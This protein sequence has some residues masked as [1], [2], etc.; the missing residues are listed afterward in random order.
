[1]ATEHEVKVS[2][3]LALESVYGEEM[4]YAVDAGH[5]RVVG[6]VDERYELLRSE[7]AEYLPPDDQALLKRSFEFAQAAHDGQCRKSGE[8]FIAHPVEVALILASLR[9]DAETLAAALLHDVVEDTA[10]TYDQML[11]EFGESIAQLVDG[12]T[13]I[14]RVEVES[15]TAEQAETIRKMLVAMSKDIRVIVIKLADRLHNMRTLYALKED[16]RIFKSRETLEIYAPIAHRLGISSIK[17]ELEDLAFYYLEPAKFS[18]VS[19]MV[20][21]SRSERESYIRNVQGI[22]R[23]EMAAVGVEC[24]IMGRPK[25]LYSIYQKMMRQG[26]GFSEIYDLIA[27]R[28]ITKS[29][30]DC[31]S[32]LGAV[33]SLWHPVPGRFKDYIAMPKFNMYQSLHTTV[34]GPAGRPL[35]VQIRTEEMHRMSEYGVAAHWRYKESGGSR[36]LA[37]DNYSRQL[38]WL[39]EMIDWQSDTQDSREFLKS[40]KVDLTPNDVFVF[41]PRGEVRQLRAG[42][43]PI[44]FAYAIHTE[45][46]HRCVGAKVD[47]RI[48]PLNYKLQMGDRVDIL[49]QKGAHPSRDWLNLVK[50]PKARTK[51]RQYLSKASRSDDLQNGQ[52]RLRQEIRK[53]GMGLSSAQTQRA[54]REVALSMGYR[55]SEEMLIK[56]GAGKENAT[57]VVNRLL[58]SV[59]DRANAD[60]AQPSIGV[61]S[62]S[63]G[64]MPPMITSVKRPKHHETHTESGVVV[65]GISNVLVKLAKCCNAVPGDDIVGF[66]TRGR[67]VSVHRRDCP[68]AVQLLKDPERII[69]VEWDA[70]EQTEATYK[71]EI[72]IEALDRMSLLMDVAAVFSSNGANVLRSMTNAHSDGMVEMRFI[73]Q[74]SD[75]DAILR[76]TEGLR[77]VE[78]VFEARR[79]V[80]G[81]GKRR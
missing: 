42:S 57:R 60:A 79:E 46:G 54:V 41:T 52:D 69:E 24:Q 26:K 12:V 37:N 44:D 27:L 48:V 22:L 28:I 64:K 66:V 74:I 58:K 10:V 39:R 38:A 72:V 45:V 3:P 67:G 5:L 75:I 49:T 2:G 53:H 62:S 1:M 30:K 23:D 13:K 77:G 7:T 32:A 18:Q 25:H 59:V 16:R 31:Y 20:A 61:S 55:D 8:P 36:K 81:V 15:L 29:V 50:T 70:R 68:N 78:G 43:T 47:G 73:V 9:M 65:K 71:V 40:L 6:G 34:I 17:W 63:T 14:T 11:L 56:I 51:I 80:P 4:G 19:R 21:A 76:I 33:H 35:E